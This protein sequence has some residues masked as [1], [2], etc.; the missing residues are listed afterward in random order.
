[1]LYLPRILILCFSAA[2]SAVYAQQAPT[3][4]AASAVGQIADAQCILAGRVS[5][6]GR[7]APQAQ[8]VQLLGA[9]GTQIRG[10]NQAAIASVRAVR[11]SEPALLTQC[12]AG[13]AMA[14]GLTAGGVKGAVPALKAGDAPIAV[15]AM[16]M[17]AGRG[18]AQWV[19]LRVAVP[20]ER[21]TLL[22]R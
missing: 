9:G 16:A 17:L 10:A 8:G 14:D 5:N 19:E 20:A 12:N 6:D 3:A 2:A 7:W 22:T 13:Q 15:Q 11:L 18:N 21:V 4:I 1:M